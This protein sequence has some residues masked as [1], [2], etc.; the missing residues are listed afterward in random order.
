MPKRFLR[1]ES[2]VM[3]KEKSKHRTP[4]PRTK[5]VFPVHVHYHIHVNF[6]SITLSGRKKKKKRDIRK[7]D[8]VTYSNCTVSLFFPVLRRKR[9]FS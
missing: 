2:K 6:V 3:F 5:N 1:D 9:T 7:T 4:T 8:I